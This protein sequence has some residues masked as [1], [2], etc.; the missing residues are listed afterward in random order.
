MSN[1]IEY[2]DKI[3]F[4]PGYY[5]KEIIEESGL[6]Q[7]D[8]AK[9]L[10]TS[11]KNLSLLVRGEQSLSVDIA[12]KLSR[13][14]G[15]SVSYW[16]NLQSSYDALVAEFKS[17]E[18]LINEK[19]VWSSLSYKYFREHFHLP[20]LSRKTDEQITKVRNF[21][22]VSTL[23]VLQKKDMAV[24]FRSDTGEL[25]E[26]NIIKANVMVQI[27]T[28]IAL[29]MEAPNFNRS[30]FQEAVMFALKFTKDHS[31][32]YP[33]IKEA[34]FKA[35]VIFVILP[36]IPGSKINGA[37]KKIGH[38]I[39]LLVNDRRLYSDTFWFTL[40]HEIGHVMN[41]DYG[42]SFESES[43]EQEEIADKFAED[44]L[45]PY[46]LYKDFITKNK[47]DIQSICEFAHEIDRDPGIILGR[48]LNDEKVKYSD[49]SLQSLRHKYK[50]KM[51]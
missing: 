43:G 7:E 9:R 8:F 30:R 11:P 3:A 21:L 49:S 24:S 17:K 19:K 36:N 44:M 47:F 5:V 18:E 1:Y 27:A 39:M 41:G 45:I 40:F 38:N 34:F 20:N 10:D 4:H 31:S 14:I 42:I 37:T 48:L 22:N 50:V 23:T 32:F 2:D 46:D 35:G 33:R 12:M 29:K 25:S 6:T 28:N 15:T 16:L 26:S 51:A 13:M